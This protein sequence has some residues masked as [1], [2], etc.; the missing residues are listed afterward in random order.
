M[1]C[2][3][4]SPKAGR[5]LASPSIRHQFHG[6][7]TWP[8]APHFR[9]ED[10]KCTPQPFDCAHHFPWTSILPLLKSSK[11]S[12]LQKGAVWEEASL[13]HKRLL[14]FL[15]QRLHF[16]EIPIHH[17]NCVLAILQ[18]TGTLHLPNRQGCHQRTLHLSFRRRRVASSL[19]GQL[20]SVLC[21]PPGSAWSWVLL[22]VGGLSTRACILPLALSG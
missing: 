8:F 3:R 20:L 1:A 21:G 22:G 4:L 16:P 13:F 7:T 9:R 12:A 11:I 18:L 17:K 6:S 15:H 10:C 19:R 5:W 14:D 2:W